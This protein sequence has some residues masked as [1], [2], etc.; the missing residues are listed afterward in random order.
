MYFLQD[1]APVNSGHFILKRVFVRSLLLLSLLF[2]FIP[3]FAN[4][5]D[6]ADNLETM[7]VTH[8]KYINVDESSPISI[9]T[10]VPNAHITISQDNID[11]FSEHAD[12]QGDC[13]TSLTPGG[14]GEY[15]ITV[16]AD[17]RVTY[18]GTI[19]SGHIWT[20]NSS[21][22]WHTPANWNTNVVPNSSN[23]VFIPNDCLYY[24]VTSSAAGNCQDLTIASS[25][26][27]TVGAYNL[28]VYG[29]AFIKGQ[30][31]MTSG[32]S[33]NV[34]A[35]IIWQNGATVAVS[36]ASAQIYCW[37]DMNFQQG[38]NVQF[39]MGYVEF[40]STSRNCYL[41]NQSTN[42]QLFHLR[43]NVSHPYA[44]IINN[45]SSADIVIKGSVWNYEGKNSSCLY[46]G[47][48][49]IKGNVT[50]FNTTANGMQWSQGMVILDGTNQ[51]VRMDGAAS[52]LK[53]LHI[54]ASG[55]VSLSGNLTL[56]GNLSFQNGYLNPGANTI[57]IGGHWSNNVGPSAFIE[58]GSTVVF[59]GSGHQYCYNSEDF[60]KLV[61]N[62]SSG[63][64]RVD[65]SSIAVTC[66]SYQW[67]SGSVDLIK[68]SF[69]AYSLVNN[70]IAGGW[71]V[72]SGST[73]NLHNTGAGAWID[74]TGKIYIFGGSF[75]VYGGST[76][77]YWPFANNA[78]IQMSGGVLDFKDQGV[79]LY[80]GF[81]NFSSNITG[82]TIRVNGSFYG[83]RTDFNPTGGVIELVGSVDCILSHGAGSNFHNVK[84]NKSSRSGD[85][86]PIVETDK[87]GNTQVRARANTVTATTNLVIKGDFTISAGSFNAPAQMSVA[88]NWTNN[89]GATGF[90]AGTGTVT[91]DKDDGEQSVTGTNYFNNVVDEN[92]GTSLSFTGPT[93][94]NGDL[95]INNTV[96]FSVNANLHN[97]YNNNT[98]NFSG[99][100]TLHNVYNNNTVNFSG[101]AELQNV[102]NSDP[103]AILEFKNPQTYTVT[104][105]TG[106]GLLRVNSNS[107]VTIADLTQ[108]GLYGSYWVNAGHLIINQDENNWID[109]NGNMT[110]LSNGVVDIYGGISDLFFGYNGNCIFSMNSGEFNVRNRG[111]YNSGSYTREF[112]ISG[113][114]IRCNG[115]WVDHSGNFNPTG[116]TV[117]FTGPADASVTLE[118]TSWFHNLTVNKTALRLP[119]EPEY[120]TD[121]EGNTIPLTRAHNLTL[122]A[123]TIK[124]YLRIT[125]AN[126]VKLGGNISCINQGDI[127]VNAGILNLNG[128]TLAT[129]GNIGVYGELK[130][131]HG[132]SLLM[133]GGKTLSIH[134]GGR[135]SCFGNQASY[136]TITH[137]ASGY[138]GITIAPGGIISAIYTIF[139]YMNT[140]GVWVR[141]GGFV[142][143]SYP[144]DYCIFRYG[145]SGGRL[146]WIDNDQSLTI[147]GAVFPTV[148]GAGSYN[149]TKFTDQGSLYFANWSGVFGGARYE[150]D[151]YNRIYWEGTGT[152]PAPQLSISKVPNSSN[153][154]LDWTYPFAASSYRI[155]RRTDPNG[156]FAYWT[157]TAN[158]YYIITPTSTHYFYMVK[159]EVP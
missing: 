52:Y 125:E 2:A 71:Y 20:G 157:S 146:L 74:L 34:L 145:A 12:G 37:G 83:N 75:N 141:T 59:N 149:V 159:A 154:R 122:N 5:M 56:K 19:N 148:T 107:N 142:D 24:P 80:D 8:T 113:G 15:E 65:G 9:S 126:E 118:S 63:A 102:Y 6:M 51:Q 48:V 14:F 57:T 101:G 42:T 3:L 32:T 134:S 60:N 86:T 151:S 143:S 98:V 81:S 95:T 115:I 67:I 119:N 111:I 17:N 29:D 132:S 96:N 136:T 62:K 53:N 112:D 87:D 116:G 58:G 46:E 156:T 78:S 68:G 97:V 99:N 120:V 130:L 158:K 106:G 4:E 45:Y 104:N 117:E 22:N 16:T 55:T 27:L 77:C 92:T 31:A 13:S 105:Y 66:A 89:V 147:T 69:T 38:S 43:T 110:I 72:N 25:A 103:N 54:Y 73:L 137:N 35:D 85:E 49:S 155:Y 91:F 39:A 21:T 50:D 23:D 88:G 140:N 127:T 123:M 64:L 7:T 1:R 135:L 70:S 41:T 11:I 144:F 138:Y 61:V 10:G 30:L 152:Q 94:V 18:R 109:L 128:K 79:Y 26:S 133:S 131:T 124:G 129:T 153:L 40:R 33:L 84:I 76:P 108:N 100:A 82:G 44:F 47:N 150:Q 121:R 114:T 36:N 28:T 93:T 90:A 139:E